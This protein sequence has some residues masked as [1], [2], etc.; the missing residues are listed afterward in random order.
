MSGRATV[1]NCLVMVCCLFSLPA[2]AVT[3]NA[4]FDV[5]F[6]SS[7]SA[8]KVSGFELGKLD[9]WGSHVLDEDRR[10]KAFFELVIEESSIGD[11]K[12]EPE[13]LWMEYAVNQ[14]LKIRAGRF[15]TA[16]GYWNRTFHHGAHMQT[17]VF[18]PLFLEFEDEAL[19]ML[20]SHTVGVMVLANFKPAAG[21]LH[22]ELQAGNGSYYDGVQ[23]NPNSSGDVDNNKAIATR[24]VFSPDYFQ[25][26]GLGLSYYT[27]AVSEDSAGNIIKLVDQTIVAGE[28][29]YNQNNTEIILEYFSINNEDTAGISRT[30][31]A[32]Y[33]H[34]AYTIFDIW[35]PY[36]RYETLEDIDLSDPYFNRL[37]TFRYEHAIFGVRYDLADNSS[38]KIEAM[39][40]DIPAAVD[41]TVNSL[42]SQWTLA[43]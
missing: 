33:A 23:L 10:I 37:G 27:S 31:T 20:P 24:V 29:S 19:A 21:N 14:Q 1:K 18:R 26:L 32:W 42:R 35:T 15:H 41:S 7:D 17:S 12:F 8:G 28:L 13:R 43:F 5:V 38:I 30:S 34:G 25:G 9:L 4:F 11:F 39:H 3:F 6:E 22:L 2:T 16:L 36:V 40:M